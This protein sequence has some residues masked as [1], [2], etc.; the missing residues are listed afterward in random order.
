V[1]DDRAPAMAKCKPKFA[2]K[3]SYNLQ[4]RLG[5]IFT[6]YYLKIA[7][8]RFTEFET[9][10]RLLSHDP[11]LFYSHFVGSDLAVL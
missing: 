6:F 3:T 8:I 7:E 4:H 10:A 9:L 11:P 2:I 1:L 5:A